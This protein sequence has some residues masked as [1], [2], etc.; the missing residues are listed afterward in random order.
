[1]TIFLD[2]APNSTNLSEQ[3]IRELYLHCSGAYLRADAVI[4]DIVLTSES[5]ALDV[6]S[7]PRLHGLPEQSVVVV[8]N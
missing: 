1:M 7:L 3:Q 6:P 2:A 5:V 4:Y 8:Q